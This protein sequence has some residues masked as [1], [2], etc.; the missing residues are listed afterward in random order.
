M[1]LIL[2]LRRQRQEDLCEF[3]ANLIYSDF[4]AIHSYMLRLCLKWKKSSEEYKKK[5][6]QRRHTNG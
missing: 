3:E 5:P 6:L 1:L 4:Q 2:A